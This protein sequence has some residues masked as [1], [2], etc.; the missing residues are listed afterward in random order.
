MFIGT[1]WLVLQRQF[2]P[3]LFLPVFIVFWHRILFPVF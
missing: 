2:Y 1:I 3:R